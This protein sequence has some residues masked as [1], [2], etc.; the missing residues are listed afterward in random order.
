[1]TSFLKR[2]PYVCRISSI[3]QNY[4]FTE[5]RAALNIPKSVDILGHIA[6]LPPAAQPSAL[7]T[8]RAIERRAMLTQTPQPG[9]ARLMRYLDARGIRTAICTRNYEE[10][11]RHFLATSLP[12]RPAAAF[13]PIVTRD[14]KPPK[15]DP[16]GILHIAR[17]WGLTGGGEGRGEKGAD[18]SGLIMVGDSFDDMAAGRRAGAATVLLVNDANRGLAESECTDLVIE[19]LDN[20]EA[21]LDA[22][23][24]GRQVQVGA[25]DVDEEAKAR[26]PAS[27]GL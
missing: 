18:A 1:M 22:G 5:M 13:D 2:G 23:F 17:Q 6:S 3:P 21:I 8:V 14:F 24:R 26:E 10:P 27:A 7:Q 4:M 9:L 16:A 12:G 15:P 20:L 25:V 11:V 19:S